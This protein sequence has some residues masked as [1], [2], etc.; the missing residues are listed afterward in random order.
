MVNMVQVKLQWTGSI[1]SALQT[2]K[3]VYIQHPSSELNATNVCL[4]VNDPLI[5]YIDPVENCSANF[6]PS[7]QIAAQWPHY[8]SRESRL[9][10][11]VRSRAITYC[12]HL[13]K[14]NINYR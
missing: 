6:Q 14:Q 13:T 3:F 7:S 2:I 12:L 10:V 9:S 11:L 4:Y 5:K 1:K 8:N